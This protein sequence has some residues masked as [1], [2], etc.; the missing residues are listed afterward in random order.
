M[1]P[2]SLKEFFRI[3]V[4]NNDE[5]IK[6]PEWKCFIIL[7]DKLNDIL[8]ELKTL[9]IDKYYIYPDLEK[10]IDVRK[11]DITPQSSVGDREENHE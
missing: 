2:K 10:D 6:E 3:P 9:G 7:P 1:P 8:S 4:F 11:S 5:K